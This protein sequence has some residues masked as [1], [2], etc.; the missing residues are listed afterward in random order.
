MRLYLGNVTRVSGAQARSG[1]GG[2]F[3]GACPRPDN[4]TFAD[5]VTRASLGRVAGLGQA[6]RSGMKGKGNTH[7]RDG[8]ICAQR[9]VCVCPTNGVAV[10]TPNSGRP[11]STLGRTAGYLT[12]V[13][14]YSMSH[15]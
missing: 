5:C 2:L 12:W 3:S 8:A 9:P 15:C 4:G 11:Q 10:D 1:S 7:S 14:L 13:E 6:R